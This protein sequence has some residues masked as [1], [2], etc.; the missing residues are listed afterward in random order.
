[1]SNLDPKELSN[2]QDLQDWIEALENL[3]LFEGKGH[4]KKLSMIFSS[5]QKIKDL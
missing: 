2:N 1:M 3:N 4:T 5:M